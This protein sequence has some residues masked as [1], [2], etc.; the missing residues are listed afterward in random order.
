MWSLGAVLYHLLCGTPPYQGRVENHGAQMLRTIMTTDPDFNLLRKEGVSE[1]GIDFIARLL[2]RDPQLRPR[3]RECLQHPWLVDVEDI[4]EYP[5]EEESE[6][7]KQLDI[8]NEESDKEDFPDASQL[9]I[10]DNDDDDRDRG[11]DAVLSDP[12]GSNGV[13]SKRPRL[14]TDEVRYPELPKLENLP[15]AAFQPPTGKAPGRLFGE[16]T[17]SAP[18]QPGNG[19]ADGD[20]N[21]SEL[22]NVSFSSY[23]SSSGESMGDADPLAAVHSVPMP[24][25]G[26]PSTTSPSLQGESYP[27][28]D[29]PLETASPV[30]TPVT[31][32]NRRGRVST[33]ANED[34]PDS[35]RENADAAEITPRA[36]R[37]QRRW[38]DGRPMPDTASESSNPNHPEDKPTDQDLAELATTVD[39]RTGRAVSEFPATSY[40]TEHEDQATE[41]ILARLQ[42]PP[43][44]VKPRPILGKLVTV[45]GS[46]FDLT[47][48]L[49][50]RMTSWGR[51]LQATV[52]YPD[53]MDTRIPA[54]ALELTYWAP[55]LEA[56]MAEGVDWKTLP[57]LRVLLS[58]KTRKRIWVNGVELRRA[59]EGFSSYG[60]LYTGDIITVYQSGDGSQYLKFRCEFY[61]GDSARTRPADEKFTVEH[62]LLPPRSASRESSTSRTAL[63][64]VYA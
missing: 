44:F 43:T 54:Y 8:I 14:V 41:R 25:F 5:D 40:D 57:G 22:E 45:P 62:G 6:P 18:D 37:Q 27:S 4:D 13:E 3:E 38:M 50:D 30:G 48:R 36:V 58:T 56:R 46:I 24:R 31:P 1:E 52:V 2:R 61:L 47:I 16:I 34:V 21:L 35:D 42:S 20:P 9:S 17:P 11:P 60:K 49:E 10:H 12:A 26:A 33:S 32:R 15:M 59:P 39:E 64:D 29:T 23:H 55:G 28:N 63:D 7:E 51:G 19:L 53:P